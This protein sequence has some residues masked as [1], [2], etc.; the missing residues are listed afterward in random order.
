MRVILLQ[1]IRGL[2][3]IGEVKNV[4][5]GYGRNFLIPRKL[6]KVG[7]ENAMKESEA[8]S[9][10]AEVTERVQRGRAKELVETL[11]DMV[12]EISRKAND[13]GTL[14]EGIEVMDIAQA[15]RNKISFDITKD[16]INLPEPIKRIGRH[17]VEVELAP[18]IVTTVI[19]EVVSSE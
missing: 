11:K 2:G 7:T 3:K 19:I 13:K 18:N 16:M 1:N 6:A 8:L 10:R 17:T 14:F 4:A 5:D 12:V 15:L 9:R